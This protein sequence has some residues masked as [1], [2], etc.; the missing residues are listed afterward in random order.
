MSENGE[1]KFI[2]DI[3]AWREKTLKSLSRRISGGG[4]AGIQDEIGVWNKGGSIPYPEVEKVKI[5][6]NEV[7]SF[8]FDVAGSVAMFSIWMM[9]GE[10]RI[11]VKVPVK[12]APTHEIRTRLMEAYDGSR[13]QRFNQDGFD[14]FFDWI[15]KDREFATFDFMTSAIFSEKHSAIIIDR[16]TQVCLHLYI[17]I[18]T[19]LID[20]NKLTAS[21]GQIDTTAYAPYILSA[22]GDVAALDWFLV[23]RLKARIT[24][25]DVGNANA[26]SIYKVL[27]PVGVSL[28][29]IKPGEEIHDQD[30]GRCR[31]TALKALEGEAAR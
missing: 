25:S 21:H 30:G 28:A 26:P 16:M 15:W 10:I 12:L 24:R 6:N 4:Q 18:A 5:V 17:A 7:M 14:V 23:N 13:C 31:I 9:T 8:D 20:V 11:G 19:I 1:N 3:H 22:V 29:A 27:I 2:G